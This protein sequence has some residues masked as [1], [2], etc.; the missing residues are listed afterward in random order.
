MAR[1]N[2]L[3]LS[4]ATSAFRSGHHKLGEKSI[5][6][7]QPVIYPPFLNRGGKQVSRTVVFGDRGER[8][9]NIEL[10]TWEEVSHAAP[11]IV[12]VF[13]LVR[14]PPLERKNS[15]L[16]DV[17]IRLEKLRAE[18]QKADLELNH[19][20][21]REAM[22][23]ALVNEEIQN[24]VTLKIREM[25]TA[26]DDGCSI[27]SRQSSQGRILRTA[28]NTSINGCQ[29]ASSTPN[30]GTIN[31]ALSS[32][33]TPTSRSANHSEKFVGA[34][35]VPSLVSERLFADVS[36]LN[37]TYSMGTNKSKSFHIEG[38]EAD[39]STSSFD[40]M[41]ELGS[42]GSYGSYMRIKRQ[43]L[44][45]IKSKDIDQGRILAAVEEHLPSPEKVLE[46]SSFTSPAFPALLRQNTNHSYDHHH[47]HHQ[48][49]SETGQPA[50][51]PAP[52]LKTKSRSRIMHSQGIDRANS[53]SGNSSSSC[54]KDIAIVTGIARSHLLQRHNTHAAMLRSPPSQRFAERHE[55]STIAALQSP[56]ILD[57]RFRGWA[58]AKASVSSKHENPTNFY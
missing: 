18:Q 24:L 1:K 44:I 53:S 23:K 46:D 28:G 15:L 51:R 2:I 11:N 33:S 4:L 34:V 42:Q 7:A 55:D 36:P 48:S 26:S 47:P 49:T 41:S 38:Y 6:Q 30:V 22:Q 9:S 3:T 29:R 19:Q 20:L 57:S 8:N 35:T 39:V 43:P 37:K 45:V 31:N 25:T 27:Q 10:E 54:S 17:R 58:A 16:D 12:P 14:P 21:K 32:K 52:F 56:T 5:M 40:D 50:P 13:N